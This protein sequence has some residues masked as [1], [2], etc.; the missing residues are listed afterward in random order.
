MA[1]S[2]VRL[3]VRGLTPE[4]AVLQVEGWVADEAVELLAREGA[5]LLGQSRRLVLELRGVMNIDA[6]GVA[7]LVGWSGPRLALHDGAPYI[8][9]LLE[10]HGLY[11]E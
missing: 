10:R 7:L 1:Q 11:C 6:A 3:T 4:E 5:R 9:K 8:R 2:M